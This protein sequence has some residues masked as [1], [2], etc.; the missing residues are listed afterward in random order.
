[1]VEQRFWDLIDKSALDE[2]D[3]TVATQKLTQLLKD[4]GDEMIF[5]FERWFQ[6]MQYRLFNYDLWAVAY[7]MQ[8]GCSDDGFT[9]F[10]TWVISKGKAFVEKALQDPASVAEV[11]D[12]SDSE[13]WEIYAYTPIYAFEALHG[14]DAKLPWDEIMVD[15]DRHDV[16]G[17][18]WDEDELEDRYPEL[19]ARFMEDSKGS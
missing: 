17:T 8:G 6:T 1:M 3:S 18:P 10:R 5:G 7:L 19:W 2:T 4:G 15:V 9:D 14:K 12:P 16:T 13:I 11:P